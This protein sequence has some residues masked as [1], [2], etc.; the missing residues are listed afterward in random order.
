MGDVPWN[1]AIVLFFRAIMLV[2][3]LASGW[4]RILRMFSEMKLMRDVRLSCI[5]IVPI[6]MGSVFAHDGQTKPCCCSEVE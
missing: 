5:E 2:P 6:V 3:T 4:K 1:V